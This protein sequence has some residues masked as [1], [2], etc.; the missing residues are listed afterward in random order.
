M[1]LKQEVPWPADGIV[2]EKE[3]SRLVGFSRSTIRRWA[4]GGLF[5]KPRRI[6][7]RSLVWTVADLRAWASKLKV[8]A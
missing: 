7:S 1:Q 3:V 4:D 2:R 8:I 6:G 5:P